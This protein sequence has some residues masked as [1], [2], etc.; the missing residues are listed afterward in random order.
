MLVLYCSYGKYKTTHTS[1]EPAKVIRKRQLTGDWV[2]STNKAFASGAL[3]GSFLRA[4]MGL[5]SKKSD[6]RG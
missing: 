4:A 3:N 1:A 5:I 2:P 6:E